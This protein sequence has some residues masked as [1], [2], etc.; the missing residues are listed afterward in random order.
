M[1]ARVFLAGA[2]GAIGT[3]LSPL[4]LQDGPASR[5]G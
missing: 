2:T 4:L 3:R 1:G 5:N